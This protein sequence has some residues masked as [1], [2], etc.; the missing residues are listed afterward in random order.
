[1]IEINGYTF[2][3]RNE[4]TQWLKLS[5]IPGGELGE[6]YHWSNTMD[7]FF[8][9]LGISR[10]IFC[11]KFGLINDESVFPYFDCSKKDDII[12]YL[13]SLSNQELQ[14]EIY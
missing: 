10:E 1:M 12:L 14:Y 13:K 7:N 5:N 6:D 3:L 8:K 4:K 9:S 2:E 11:E